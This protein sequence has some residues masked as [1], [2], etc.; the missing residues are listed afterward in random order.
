MR[1][2]IDGAF[3]LYYLA[4]AGLSAVGLWRWLRGKRAGRRGS[5]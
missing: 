3:V 2:V 1:F 5:E 4:L